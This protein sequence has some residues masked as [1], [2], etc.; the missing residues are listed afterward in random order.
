MKN[1][2]TNNPLFLGLSHIGQV[3]SI[4]WTKKIGPCAVFDFNKNNLLKFKKN[5]FTIEE[6]NLSKI[7]FNKKKINFCKSSNEIKKYKNIFFTYD[8][9]LDNEGNP[10]INFIENKLK[11]L[12]KI[13]FE[14]QTLIIITSQVYPG[15]TDY[16]KKKYL[17]KNNLIKLIYM[18]DT[19]KMGNAIERFLKPEQLVFGC[20]IKDKNLILYLFKKFN[21]RKYLKSYKEAELIKISLNLYLYFSVNFSNIIENFSKQIGVNYLKI[22]ENLK[23]DKRIGTQSYINP[24]PAIS[25]GHLERDVFY[26]KK[27]NKNLNIKKI[28][29]SFESFN[30][31]RNNELKNIITN[32]IKER[33]I[34]LLIIG[35][36]YK[37]SSLSLVNS[38]FQKIF[39]TKKIR[40]SYYDSY[41]KENIGNNF[42]L[43]RTKNLIKGLNQADIVILNYCSDNDFLTIKKKFSKSNLKKYL[44][45]ISIK[46]QNFFKKN[47]HVINFYSSS[48]NKYDQ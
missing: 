5:N 13:K 32:S 17:K 22:I 47:E 28:F 27:E 37:D 19:L 26:L 7:N 1:H 16:I 4:A 41:F 14:K 35:L 23:K 15:F 48:R 39:K 38:V 11:E 45:N 8:T 36:S 25:G 34:K 40:T 46:Y 24:S 31:M 33:V 43:K 21:C 3:Y 10:N 29:S 2:Q 42:K 9:P 18:V 6:R 30:Q 20:N 12:L 44:V